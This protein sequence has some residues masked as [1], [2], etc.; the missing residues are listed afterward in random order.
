MHSILAHIE[1]EYIHVLWRPKHMHRLAPAVATFETARA[2]FP[3]RQGSS[4]RGTITRPYG[5]QLTIGVH[6][7][8]AACAL[9]DACIMIGGTTVAPQVAAA[10][11]C[12]WAHFVAWVDIII[13]VKSS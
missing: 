8:Y 12:E 13:N 11:K 4:V 10:V 1:A 6:T 9:R 3:Q 7:S 5:A 2:N